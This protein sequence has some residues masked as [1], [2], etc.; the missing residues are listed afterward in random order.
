MT[1]FPN[2]WS[3]RD[4]KLTINRNDLLNSSYA[5]LSGF[6]TK[7]WRSK[8]KI[9]FQNEPGID[10]G[11]L[12]KEFITILSNALFNPQESNNSLFKFVDEEQ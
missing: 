12:Y 4:I 2:Y 1:V 11:G 8:W 7:A 10:G 5:L 9:A 6:S 3:P